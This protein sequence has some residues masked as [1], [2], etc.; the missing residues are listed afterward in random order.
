[1]TFAEP[2]IGAVQAAGALVDVQQAPYLYTLLTDWS[3]TLV[4]V[5][6]A[7]VGMAAVLGTLRFLNGW[8]LKPYIYGA[9]IPTL[10][11]REHSE[12][13]GLGN[14]PFVRFS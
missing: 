12:L 5:V 8:S 7:G 13:S 3:G 9:L 4:L 6:G 1:M 14:M 10:L 11:C 2:A